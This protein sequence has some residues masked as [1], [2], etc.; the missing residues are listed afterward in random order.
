MSAPTTPS[1]ATDRVVRQP[2][3][4]P[5]C[6]LLCDSVGVATG[7]QLSLTG[8]ECPRARAALATFPSHPA[9]AV[10][11][12]DGQPA[13]AAEALAAAAERLSHARQ[14]L[15][16][17]LAT[18]VAGARALYTLANQCGAILDHAHGAAMLPSLRS[19]QD[20]GAFTTSLAE[21]RNRA[22]LILCIG[23]QPA[24]KHPEFFRRC[25]IGEDKEQAAGPAA[26]DIVFL[27]T[28]A[29]PATQGHNNV[30]VSEVP[31]QGDLL[32]SLAVLNTLCRPKPPAD[33]AF[34]APELRALGERLRTAQYIALVVT[35]STLA[36]QHGTHAALLLESIGHLTKALNRTTRA[37]VLSLGGDDGGNTVNYTMTWLSGLPLRTAVRPTGLDHDPHRYDTA[38]LL[39][40]NAV[41]AVLWVASL[42]PDLPPPQTDLP[43]VVLGHPALAGHMRD[44]RGVF[45]PVSTPGIGSAGHMFRTD[46]GV[47]LPLVPVRED[48]L[49]TVAALAGQLLQQLQG[50]AMHREG[51]A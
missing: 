6:A 48:G 43:L 29:D 36:D 9:D 28:P 26:R 25:G 33:I 49:P 39:A 47:V 45:L 22:D 15:F 18:D 8:A 13:T 19:L 35:P 32:Q 38:R 16:G 46:G 2:W 23:T 30:T 27:G 42:T 5:F 4:C 12:V 50:V 34:A 14:P 37:G 51:A 31:L 24:A 1:S 41:D 3:T 10:A 20:R 11:L 21:V 40:D 44:R 17:G 7:E